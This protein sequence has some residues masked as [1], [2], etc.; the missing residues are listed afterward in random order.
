M[1]HL[2]HIPLNIV[3][4]LLEVLTDL[5]LGL[6]SVHSLRSYV[7]KIS[8]SVFNPDRKCFVRGLHARPEL[9]ANR[10]RLREMHNSVTILHLA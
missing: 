7:V 3:I 6:Y 10:F 4:S 9:H 5:H 2:E 8:S 1:F